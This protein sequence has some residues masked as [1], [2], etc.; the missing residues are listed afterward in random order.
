MK[1]AM[2][3][4]HALCVRR[5]YNRFNSRSGPKDW[6]DSIVWTLAGFTFWLSQNLRWGRG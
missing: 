6:K 3:R 1:P 4:F 2:V 5:V